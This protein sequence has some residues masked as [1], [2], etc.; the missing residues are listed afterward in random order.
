MEAEHSPFSINIIELLVAI[1]TTIITW[2]GLHASISSYWPVGLNL[3]TPLPEWVIDKR[4]TLF[5]EWAI[6]ITLLLATSSIFF[7]RGIGNERIQYFSRFNHFALAWPLLLFPLVTYLSIFSLL[8]FPIGLMLP[9][10]SLA[11]PIKS[12]RWWGWMFTTIWL[13]SCTIIAWYYFGRIDYL[14]GD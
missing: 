6:P 8:C 5:H 10:L 11:E 4:E 1:G 12:R 13:V 2:F 3:E 9:V 7:V 14:F